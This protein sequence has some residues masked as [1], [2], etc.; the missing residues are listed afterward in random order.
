MSLDLSEPQPT[1]RDHIFHAI[2]NSGLV[3]ALGDMDALTAAVVKRLD[4]NGLLIETAEAAELTPAEVRA[5]MGRN[6]DGGYALIAA[7]PQGDV[8]WTRE[9]AKE[10][11]ANQGLGDYE[12]MI[13]VAV[14]ETVGEGPVPE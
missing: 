10:W 8:D 9:R 7:N 12:E 2:A 4:D 3:V 5:Y 14:I 1:T 6:P 13:L 11:L